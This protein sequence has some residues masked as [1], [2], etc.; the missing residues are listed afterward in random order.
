VAT[1]E[2]L[3]QDLFDGRPKVRRGAAKSLGELAGE[4]AIFY[5]ETALAEERVVFVKQ[6]I[7]DALVSS[8]D[9]HALEL[10]IDALLY[11]ERAPSIRNTIIE[12][13]VTRNDA[14]ARDAMVGAVGRAP[15]S[16][17]R[18]AIIEALVRRDDPHA[19]G[20]MVRAIRDSGPAIG[21]G[22][23]TTLEKR[24]DPRAVELKSR[25]QAEERAR[26]RN[27][28]IVRCAQVLGGFI[29]VGTVSSFVVWAVVDYFRTTSAGETVV[30]EVRHLSS[31]CSAQPFTGTPRS[32]QGKI[33]VWDMKSNDLSDAQTEISNERWLMST[34]E[35]ATVV[36][37]LGTRKEEVGRYS[38]SGQP[39][40]RE[41]VDLCVMY[42]PETRVGGSVTIISRDPVSVREVEHQPEF[43]DPN[44]P[45]GEWIK[46]N[47]I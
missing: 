6:A 12:A 4:D 28:R 21:P 38:I 14:E 17:V 16:E 45:I 46:R 29:L 3:A 42:W 18:Q 30:K 26:R 5:L 11:R 43:G 2:Q 41:Y 33:L 34:E 27:A 13:L 20:D 40:Y 9:P 44:K 10:A 32:R 35:Q 15:N 39:A 24:G 31:K 22:I 36:M 25:L 37:V 1:M 7:L 8:R 19:F 47:L 23:V